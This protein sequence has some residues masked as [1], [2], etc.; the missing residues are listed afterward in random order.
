MTLRCKKEST[1]W[2]VITYTDKDY[3]S[4][5]F[6]IVSGDESDFNIA[7]VGPFSNRTMYSLVWSRNLT[8]RWSYVLQHD[9]GY[10]AQTQGFNA[11]NSQ[12][13]DWYGINQYLFYKINCCWTLGW[14]F[15][16][17]DDPEGYVVTGLRPGNTDAQ[18]RFPGSFYETSVGLNYKPN[19][20]LTIRP[21]VAL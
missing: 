18:F 13:A 12:H 7:G 4:L 9:L 1:S 11:V 19:G 15:E 3:G 10:Q 8:S 5:A 17:F 14:R 6:S 20:N 2:A 16:W 21:E